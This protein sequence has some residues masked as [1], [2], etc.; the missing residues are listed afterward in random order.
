[1]FLESILNKACESQIP[2]ILL[3]QHIFCLAETLHILKEFGCQSYFSI[4]LQL[5]CL[6][7][8]LYVFRGFQICSVEF[9]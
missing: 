6:M 8:L 3:S 4:L 7:M 5:D 1:M 9:M 2:L